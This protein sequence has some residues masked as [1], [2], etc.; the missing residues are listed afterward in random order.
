MFGQDNALN[1]KLT[2]AHLTVM[3]VFIYSQG[4]PKAQRF[5]HV[6]NWQLEQHY[7]VP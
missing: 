3:S 2:K 1:K 7:A 6:D 5:P 4:N